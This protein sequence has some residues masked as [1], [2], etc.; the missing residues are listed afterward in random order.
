V[1]DV[2]DER[3]DA[4]QHQGIGHQHGEA[5]D[6]AAAWCLVVD[7]ADAEDRERER[8]REEPMGQLAGD[9]SVTDS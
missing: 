7:L 6:G 8:G 5:R 9:P 3:H 2:E 4:G 1:V